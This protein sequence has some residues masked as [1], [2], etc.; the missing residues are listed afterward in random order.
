MRILHVTPHLPPDQA[1]NALLPWQLGDW[2]RGAR[3]RGR[4]RG[5]SAAR[6]RQDA[7]CRAR[8]LGSAAKRGVR[9]SDPLGSARSSAR[10][11]ILRALAPAI[12]RADLVHVHSN[13]L[14][15]GTGRPARAAARE[16]GRADA[17]RHRDLALQP[18]RFRP[19]LFTRAYRAASYVTFYSDRLMIARARART[20]PA[21][22]ARDLPAGRRGVRLA[23]RGGAGE[24]ARGARDHQ[25]AP[26]A[27]RQ[28]AA[29]AGRAARPHRSDDRR[30]CTCTRIRGS[31][32]AGRGRCSRS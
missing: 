4:V 15:A 9:R 11:R 8:D 10:S 3:R 29:P 16:A 13:G 30:R 20:R 5:A 22:R 18:K 24:G 2:A 21:R 1:A 7:A 12:A 25:P 31:S 32:S 6:E 27:E 19:D 26:A 14:L 23:R 28:A 17:V